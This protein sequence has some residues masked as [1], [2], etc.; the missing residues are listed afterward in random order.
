[1][2]KI[3]AG[4]VSASPAFLTREKALVCFQNFHQRLAVVLYVLWFS[5]SHV[6]PAINDFDP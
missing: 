4:Q 1:M 6:L 2:G 5:E 3:R